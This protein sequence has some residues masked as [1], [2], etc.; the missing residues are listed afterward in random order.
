MGSALAEREAKKAQ[1]KKDDE[2]TVSWQ[3]G[4]SKDIGKLNKWKSKLASPE[5]TDL[6][7]DSLCAEYIRRFDSHVE[8]MSDIRTSLAE[9]GAKP[10][11]MGAVE[12]FYCRR[13][14]Q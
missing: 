6:L 5:L 3:A 2:Q 10:V 7:P 12:E 9:V 8:S 13:W 14:V 1:A 4:L 11:D